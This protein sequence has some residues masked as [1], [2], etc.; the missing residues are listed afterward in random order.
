MK[1]LHI[2]R[3][4]SVLEPSM[5]LAI[6]GFDINV[7]G[8]S[9]SLASRTRRMLQ[10]AL[11]NVPSYGYKTRR[12]LAGYLVFARTSLKLLVAAASVVLNRDITNVRP[13]ADYLSTPRRFKT[14]DY[15]DWYREHPVWVAIDATLL[16]LGIADA[17]SG[18]GTP[19]PRLP[20]LT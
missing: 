1:G 14:Q 17:V 16:Q 19:L 15:H 7:L 3:L 20:N 5:E 6:L 12:R 4:K 9:I 18:I 13:L 11:F 8:G 2:N 10:K